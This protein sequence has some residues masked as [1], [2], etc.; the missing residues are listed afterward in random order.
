MKKLLLLGLLIAF[1]VGPTLVAYAEEKPRREGPPVGAREGKPPE[2]ALTDA[3]QE[4]MKV[5]LNAHQE[6]VKKLLARAIEVL[7][8]KDGRMFVMQHTMKSIRGPDRPRDGAPQGERRREDGGE[9]PKT[10]DRER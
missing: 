10:P 4:A 5:E 3:Q 2:I 8:D 6:A 7:G 9:K 1:V